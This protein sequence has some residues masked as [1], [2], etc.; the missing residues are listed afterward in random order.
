M[1]NILALEKEFKVSNA[2]EGLYAAYF[3]L[4]IKRNVEKFDIKGMLKVA[5]GPGFMLF[6]VNLSYEGEGSI[7]FS[8]RF[9]K[10]LQI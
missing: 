3:I 7:C 8:V 4:Q 2:E 5:M 1:K 10:F 9:V 6:L